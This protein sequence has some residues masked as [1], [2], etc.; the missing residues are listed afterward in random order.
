LISATGPVQAPTENISRIVETSAV[1]GR[2]PSDNA[3]PN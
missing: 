1:L 2:F 3:K